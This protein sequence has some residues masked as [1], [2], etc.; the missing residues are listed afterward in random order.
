MS[1]MTR[2]EKWIWL[3]AILEGEGS[4]TKATTGGSLRITLGMT[5]KDTVN[6]AAKLMSNHGWPKELK[7]GKNKSIYRFEVS[8]ERAAFVARQIL[9]YMHSRRR[10]KI[11]SILKDWYKRIME[12]YGIVCRRCGGCDPTFAKMWKGV[13][14]RTMV[15]AP[16]ESRHPHPGDV[17]YCETLVK[18]VE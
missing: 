3:A 7:R 5:D 11:S 9:P 17:A 2:Q 13:N 12:R 6:M 18:Q 8:G 10:N 16:S 4:F 1:K 14:K 15:K